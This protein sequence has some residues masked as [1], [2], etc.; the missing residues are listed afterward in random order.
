MALGGGAV[1]G[2]AH[3]GVLKALQEANV[4]ISFI[5]GTSIGSLVG[6]LYAFGIPVEDIENIANRLGWRDIT[7]PSV[8]KFGLL[9][10]A[11]LKETLKKY[12]GNKRIEGAKVPFSA[13]ATDVSTGQKVVLNSG[14]VADAVMASTCI[15]GLF[16][17][18]EINHQL[19]I[20]G[21]IV[22]NV[23]V[24]TVRNMG[25]GFTIAVDLGS[26]L[27]NTKPTNVVDVLLN[28]FHFTMQQAV[29]KQLE[30]ADVVMQPNLA[31]FS[32]VNTNQTSAL[33][34][35][36]YQEAKRCLAILEGNTLL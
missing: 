11:K 18:V 16:V 17:P 31:E 1:L 9:S 5:S 25:A 35:E 12:I 8:S 29:Q 34:R 19:L 2:T 36:G 22:E 10:N 13:V 26:S 23:P 6:V 24:H 7:K 3:I 20:D 32:M 21:G 33:I 14:N 30:E 27:A 15:P 28:S 4:E